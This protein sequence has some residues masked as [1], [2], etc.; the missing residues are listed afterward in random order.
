M[1]EEHK[2]IHIIPSQI[3]TV[4]FP[5]RAIYFSWRYLINLKN[6]RSLFQHES[7]LCEI[8]TESEPLNFANLPHA[9]RSG[10]VWTGRIETGRAERCDGD[11]YSVRPQLDQSPT[12]W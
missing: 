6:F 12:A 8:E 4:T 2:R 7:L 10:D 5:R 11:P 1:L 3:P 9:L